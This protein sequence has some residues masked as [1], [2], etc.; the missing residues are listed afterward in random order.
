MSRNI[1]R[2]VKRRQGVQR[3]ASR[4]DDP[5][6]TVLEMERTVKSWVDEV[7][8]KQETDSRLVFSKLFG[9]RI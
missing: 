8:N 7:R 4:I 2:I 6:S 1:V 3:G 5:R 9:R